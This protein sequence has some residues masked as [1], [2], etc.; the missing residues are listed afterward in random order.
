MTEAQWNTVEDTELSDFIRFNKVGDLVEG[1]YE[2]AGKVPGQWGDQDVFY[3]Q[4]KDEKFA[5]GATADLKAKMAKVPVGS[6]TRIEYTE[7]VEVPGVGSDG[8][9]KNPMKKFLVQ[10]K[11]PAKAPF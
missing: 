2:K 1:I 4:G 9:P 6:H 7:D 8:K 10:W 3:F 5:V 11:K